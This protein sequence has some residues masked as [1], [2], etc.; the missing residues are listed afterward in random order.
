MADRL[1]FSRTV[2]RNVVLLDNVAGTEQNQG[3]QSVTHVEIESCI[4]ETASV[5]S[6]LA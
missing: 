4:I 3:A 5:C 1:L 6:S 2:V